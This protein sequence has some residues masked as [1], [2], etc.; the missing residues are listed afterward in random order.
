V[1]TTFAFF[2]TFATRQFLEDPWSELK[3]RPI[4]HEINNTLNNVHSI[5]GGDKSDKLEEE[6]A[7][8]KVLNA[9]HGQIDLVH[10]ARKQ[11][12]VL[13]NNNC[14]LVIRFNVK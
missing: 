11:M 12:K 1:G 8:V 13:M 14:V 6:P 7:F 5:L 4:P 2:A 9:K 10:Y 3:E